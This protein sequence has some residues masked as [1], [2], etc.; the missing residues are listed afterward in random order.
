ML[1]LIFDHS[2]VPRIE[3]SYLIVRIL[4]MSDKRLLLLLAT[5]PRLEGLEAK[6]IYCS[7]ED[8]CVVARFR[9]QG[10]ACYAHRASVRT[11]FRAEAPIVGSI[12]RNHAN[13]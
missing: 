3:D 2:E 12:K 13:S 7:L 8:S 1:P 11:R 5:V 4:R 6:I 10:G 9:D